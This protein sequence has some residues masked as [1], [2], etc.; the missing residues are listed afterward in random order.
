MYRIF[1]LLLLIIFVSNNAN[2][3]VDDDRDTFFLAKKKGV[4]GKLGKSI[5]RDNP[6]TEPVKI[7][8]PYKK[9]SGKIIRSIEISPLSF[10]ENIY[11]TNV[12][13]NNLAIRVANFLHKNTKIQVVR[14]NLFFREGDR[15]Q[16]LLV[17]D[18]ERY[19][20]DLTF[21]QDARIIVFGSS[22]MKDSVDILVLT[23]DVFSIG[24]KASASSLNRV[25]LEL[26]EDNI[27]GSGS[28][29]AIR[30]LYDKPRDPRFGYGAV[31]TRRNIKGTF[32]DWST[33]FETF[34]PAFNTGRKEELTIYTK[35]EKPF[36]S[37]YAQWTGALE[38]SFNR[39]ANAYRDSLFKTFRSY[40]NHAIDLWAGYNLGYK[41]ARK[42][43]AENR[44][45]HFVAARSFYIKF[46]KV[47]EAFRSGF[48][49]GYVD[50]NGALL[51][52]S[53]YKQNF[54][55]TNFIYGFGRNEDVPI[56][57]SATLI[58]GWTNKEGRRR[59]YYGVDFEGNHFSKKGYFTS[60]KV[61]FGGYSYKNELED[62]AILISGDHFTR[63]RKL[64]TQWYNRNFV[65]LSYTR[66]AKLQLNDTL[67]LKSGFGLPYFRQDAL[68]DMRT[69]IKVESV[70][71]NMRKL[72]GFRFAPFAFTELC[73]LKPV[74]AAV[75]KTNGYPAIGGGIR[76]R[77]ENLI[78]GTIEF[79][80]YYFPRTI[81][82]MKGYRFELSTNLRFKFNST[83]IKRP[84]FV[85]S[86]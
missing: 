77:N 54:Y 60:A 2:A 64:N 59:A 61:R 13:K 11:D 49:T 37:R 80:G 28:A 1:T 76:T 50:I 65:G 21:L 32:L 78:F 62:I 58:G 73:F 15:L 22:K 8:N 31:F 3:Q 56:G 40:S 5:S 82:D 33:G 72:L 63:L 27:H 19:L 14:N 7:V 12:V 79:K 34:A 74:K 85:V 45:R 17:A 24:G 48:N 38:L 20:R 53:L 4:L 30:G 81:G 43:D 86:N 57:M 6:V 84:D 67:T 35:V 66:L 71:F 25:Q 46:D 47:P 23:K 16:P 9:H 10:N 51:S 44:F 83:F 18:N 75:S 52:Y 26:R 69:T 29:F 41:R 68:G 70:F 42:S 39:N 55:R 36:V